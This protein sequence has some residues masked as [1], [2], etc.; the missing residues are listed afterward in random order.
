M[1]NRSP[2]GRANPAEKHRSDLGTL[3]LELIS[4]DLERDRID[5]LA[6]LA[7]TPA[8]GRDADAGIGLDGSITTGRHHSHDAR[9][10]HDA[11]FQILFNLAPIGVGDELVDA[12]DRAL[13][14]AD[15]GAC[16]E[17]TTE[18]DH[19]LAGKV[20]PQIADVEQLRLAR[21]RHAK[22]T[23]SVQHVPGYTAVLA[24]RREISKRE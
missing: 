2:I 14:V 8:K 13:V 20:P 7:V 11:Q 4:E 22:A 10:G 15:T 23:V 21:E 12:R 17:E 16:F 9:D 19:V 3:R 18:P 1:R 24:L 5:E 6:G